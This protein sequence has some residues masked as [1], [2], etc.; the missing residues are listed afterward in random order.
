M[1]HDLLG[2]GWWHAVL[3]V[4]TSVAVTQNLLAPSSLPLVWDA[5]SRE[6]RLAARAIREALL[7]E[8]REWVGIG[9]G[10]IEALLERGCGQREGDD[11]GDVGESGASLSSLCSGRW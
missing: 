9:A 3:N 11:E 7:A 2:A 4:E 5:I 6:D 8:G 1:T 10:E